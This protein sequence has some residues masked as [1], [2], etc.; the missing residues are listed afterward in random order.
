MAGRRVSSPPKVD[1]VF[2]IDTTG[3]MDDKIEGLVASLQALADR[4]AEK[5]ADWRVAILAFGDLT[6]A[7]DTIVATSFIGSVRTLKHSLGRLPRN[8]GGVNDGES[9]FEA[10]QKAISLSGYRS[11]VIKVVVLITDEPALQHRITSQF[12][13]AQL[14]AAEVLTFVVSPPLTY[15]QRLAK[16][17]GGSWFQVS[18]NTDLHEIL[19]LFDRLTRS[20][21]V[22]VEQVQT[23]AGGSVAGYLAL[24]PGVP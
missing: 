16:D 20:V 1:L 11:G 10:L 2:A 21:A 18:A 17:N 12:I 19:A 15:Y 4:L 6:V 7:G 24:P 8:S 23:I 3:S 5:D 14:R 22:T 13:S 9:S